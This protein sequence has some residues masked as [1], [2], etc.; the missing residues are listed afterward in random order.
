M[1]STK[2]SAG[3]KVGARAPDFDYNNYF[4]CCTCWIL[5]NCGFYPTV[6]FLQL[7]DFIQLFDFIELLISSNCSISLNCGFQ[8]T[9]I[10]SSTVT[11]T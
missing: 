6:D 1:R 3:I 8:D 4:G 9:S 11:K 10:S 5:S 7:L 2:Q